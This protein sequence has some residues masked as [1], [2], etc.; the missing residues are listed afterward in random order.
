MNKKLIIGTFLLILGV[1]F[2][3]GVSHSVR[4]M[5]RDWPPGYDETGAHW[6]VYDLYNPETHVLDENSI[7][8]Y[9]LYS[10]AQNAV[11]WTADVGNFP[12]N[13][14]QEGDT[15]IGFGAWDS[16]YVTNPS[17]Y[18]DNPNHVGFYWFF[19]DTMDADVDPQDLSPDD[20][21]RPIPK[22]IVTKFGPGG[23]GNDTIIV[24]IPNP[25]ETR[26][27]DQTEYDVLGFW[28]VAD[29][30]NS[31]T[32]NAFDAGNA[33]SFGFI[34]VD[35]VFG[36]TTEF[37][38]KESD[39]FEAFIQWTTYFAYKIVARPDT[40][41]D[42]PGYSTYY[43][44]QNSDAVIVY[45]DIVGIEENKNVKQYNLSIYSYPNPYSKNTRI[46]FTIP[47]TT[48]VTLNI[49]NTS[50]QLINTLLDETKPAGEYTIEY[51][52]VNLPSG[53]YFYQLQ[54]PEGNKTGRLIRL[55]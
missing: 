25:K 18:G 28:L 5:V 22:P 6:Y 47:R 24:R 15:I 46:V 40:T 31:G 13:D 27:A 49:Y 17:G 16:A 44:S 53:V 19:S 10:A 51:K 37:R 43:Y 21:L 12:G 50:G 38:T 26:R 52:D 20:T 14:W 30:T 33:V 7:G 48:S 36:D 34:A 1:D 55:K 54:T 45:H 39:R 23:I 29:S 8:S 32:P 41:I 4:Q 42:Q 2:A 9:T 35:G 3:C 11:R